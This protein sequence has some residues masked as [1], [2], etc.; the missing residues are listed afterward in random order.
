VNRTERWTG[1]SGGKDTESSGVGRKDSRFLVALR[2]LGL[3]LVM[4]MCCRE[5]GW[6]LSRGSTYNGGNKLL[7]PSWG[8]DAV[9]RDVSVVGESR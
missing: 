5:S 7:G 9:L 8:V 2:I 1:G 4:V 6:I 3:V